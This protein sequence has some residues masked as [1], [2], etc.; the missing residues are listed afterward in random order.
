MIASPYYIDGAEPASAAVAITP[1]SIQYQLPL[2]AMQA[3]RQMKPLLD[4]ARDSGFGKGMGKGSTTEQDPSLRVA[5]ELSAEDIGVSGIDMA[6]ILE[7]VNP[8]LAYIQQQ[9]MACAR[10]QHPLPPL[11]EPPLPNL[12]RSSPTPL[13]RPMRSL[14]TSQ[15]PARCRNQHHTNWILL[16]HHTM[17][18]LMVTHP[19]MLC[20]GSMCAGDMQGSRPKRRRSAAASGPTPAAAAAS[21]PATLSF[22]KPAPGIQP[23]APA[24]KQRKAAAGPQ[25]RTLHVEGGK[26]D[27]AGDGRVT[28]TIDPGVDMRELR[29]FLRQRFGA[30]AGKRMGSI[31]LLDPKGKEVKEA[32]GK[33]LVDGVRLKVTYVDSNT[34][35]WCAGRG[36]GL[37][38]KRGP[39]PAAR[40]LLKKAGKKTAKKPA[41]SQMVW[42]DASDPDW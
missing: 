21:G 1:T 28:F 35:Y 26:G 36:G 25:L 38:Y 10:V 18:H 9:I 6:R 22:A 5:K 27:T 11:P 8:W 40:M 34:G 19:S 23:R 13:V 24:S 7:Q 12:Y 30:Y 14:T 4:A 3:A 16:Y 29:T 33:D 32:K 15:P 20:A 2:S 37:V 39:Q 17:S 42:M 41:R 31:L